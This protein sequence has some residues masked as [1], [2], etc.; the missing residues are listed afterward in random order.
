MNTIEAIS[1][2]VDRKVERTWFVWAL[3]IIGIIAFL[4]NNQVQD[5]RDDIVDLKSLAPVL[6][7]RTINIQS[8]QAEFKTDVKDEFKQLK[9][10]IQK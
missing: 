5:N 1:G 10:L 6:N 4:V 9:I 7:E 3:G 2:R 8:D